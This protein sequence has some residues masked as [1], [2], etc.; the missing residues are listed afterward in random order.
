MGLFSSKSPQEQAI[1]A[2]LD[3]LQ[4]QPRAQG[5]GVVETR[6][7]GASRMLSSMASWI[8]RL[9]SPW[10]DLSKAERITLVARSRDAM[11]NHPLGRAA[12]V[13]VRTS[14]VGVGLICRPQVDHES[15]GISEEQAEQ[16]NT[17]LAREW[18]LYAES[19]LEC[20]AEASST[21]YQLQ[22]IALLSTLTGGDVFVATPDIERQHTLY[23]T[24]LQLL[25]TERIC[26]PNGCPD[27]DRLCE[28]I[29]FDPDSGA[30]I[31]VWLCSEYPYEKRLTRPLTWERLEVFG[32][33]TGRRR[34]LQI[35]CDKERPGQKRGAPYLSPVLEPLQKLVRCRAGS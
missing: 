9:G 20:D 30:P 13:R 21:H 34:V 29:E 7:R 28:G 4:N 18:E 27:N 15:L 10:R 26:N 2:V 17:W 23:S 22:G 1:R 5:G 6:W 33:S 25:E 32:A 35:W 11:R 3:A 16:I 14:V 8:P 12:V 24:R 19:P 31:A